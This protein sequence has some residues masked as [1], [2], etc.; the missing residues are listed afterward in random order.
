M[1]TLIVS[2]KIFLFFTAL[3]GII[4]PL[5]VTGITQV[6]F[7][8]KANGSLIR[9]GN[10]TIGSELIGQ[11][12]DSAVYF[13]TRPSAISYNPL[14]S[15]GSNYG[16]NNPKLKI[17][18][19]EQRKHFIDFNGLDSL[20]VIPSEM[21]F[22]SA[23]GVDPHISAQAALIQVNRISKARNFDSTQKQQ[24]LQCIQQH[25]ETSQF[26]VLG[27]ERVNVLLLNLDVD[28]IK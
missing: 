19:E 1:K 22:A 12:F 8:V 28:K 6:A 9:K 4:Y 5:V 23:S 25:T 17:L 11:K 3:T 10:Q 14:P 16:L 15:G 2:L 13:S 27:E 21:V 7:P 20:T 26:F 24:L 18:V